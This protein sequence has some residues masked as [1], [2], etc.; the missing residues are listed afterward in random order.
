MSN[1]KGFKVAGVSTDRNRHFNGDQFV[2]GEL[3]TEKEKLRRVGSITPT[4]LTPVTLSR[5]KVAFIFGCR[6]EL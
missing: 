6:F 4:W 5:K 1:F 2:G 3:M